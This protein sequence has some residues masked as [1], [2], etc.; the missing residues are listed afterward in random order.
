ML[1]FNR[2]DAFVAYLKRHGFV[3]VGR[4]LSP[5]RRSREVK[6][7]G[8]TLLTLPLRCPRMNECCDDADHSE[9][10]CLVDW[11]AAVP[12]EQAKWR[13]T[14]KLYTTTHV[15]ASLDGQPETVNFL[16]QEFKVSIRE[17]IT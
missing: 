14:P 10:V 15:R 16:E 6:I 9:Y 17:M 12:R 5:A 11:L 4:I 13:A 7:N 3:G 2:G 8:K 1:G